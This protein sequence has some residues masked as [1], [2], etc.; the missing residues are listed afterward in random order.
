LT[1]SCSSK[2]ASRRRP[3][4]PARHAVRRRDLDQAH[5]PQIDAASRRPRAEDHPH[6]AEATPL[7]IYFAWPYHA[8]ERGSDENFNGLLRQFLL[9]GTD[10]MGLSPL[11]VK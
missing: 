1:P 9:K 4:H 8:W 6:I 11:E 2:H 10:F 3:T 7:D 5:G